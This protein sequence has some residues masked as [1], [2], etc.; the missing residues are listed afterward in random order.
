SL[1]LCQRAL[2]E[3]P[4]IEAVKNQHASRI[5]LVPVMAAEPTGIEKLRELAV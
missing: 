2:Q 5:A 1:L 4:Q 3:L